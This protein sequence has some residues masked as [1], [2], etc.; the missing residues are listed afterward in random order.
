MVNP[1]TESLSI[2][3]SLSINYACISLSYIVGLKR[4]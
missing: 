4:R 2:H 1:L 3:Y